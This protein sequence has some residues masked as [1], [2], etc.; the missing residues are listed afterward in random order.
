MYNIFNQI[1]DQYDE[2]AINQ[3]IASDLPE[4]PTDINNFALVLKEGNKTACKYPID[5]V[6][7][8]AFSFAA[9]QKNGFKLSDDMAKVA[10]SNLGKMLNFYGI[11]HNLKIDDSIKTN[12]VNVAN[13]SEIKVASNTQKEYF[14]LDNGEIQY[15][16]LDTKDDFRLSLKEFL[17]NSKYLAPNLRKEAAA[18]FLK[19]SSELK[20]PVPDYFEKYASWEVA[21]L[22]TLKMAMAT[23]YQIYNDKI[24]EN[25][26][27]LLS[28]IA[29]AEDALKA[30]DYIS[31]VDK[32]LGVIPEKHF[33]L[34]EKF[35]KKANIEFQE[36]LSSAL[37]NKVFDE[38]L[39]PEI[40]D[41]LEE[42]GELAYDKL[43]PRLKSVIL[44]LIK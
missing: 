26:D 12:I 21:E 38:Y 19:R 34:A 16:P 8:V 28:K 5:T 17:N 33:D 10:E 40:I 3:K 20:I 22:P 44:T 11:Q 15:L 31:D 24:R 14:A 37:E 25:M 1:L 18:N 42:H 6:K 39:E 27:K 35:F 36:K 9:Y 43:N 32:K 7:N 30:I 41:L 2:R 4:K 23:R 29:N 13:A